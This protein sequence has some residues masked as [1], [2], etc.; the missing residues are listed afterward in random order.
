MSRPGVPM[1]W[2]AEKW[3]P[4]PASTMTATASSLTAGRERVVQRVRHRRV[5]GIAE[6]RPVQRDHRRP[7]AHLVADDRLVVLAVRVLVVLFRDPLSC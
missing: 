3:S 5:L 1:S 6:P 2:P 7:V 4:A